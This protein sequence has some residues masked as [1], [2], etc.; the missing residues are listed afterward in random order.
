MKTITITSHLDAE[1][2]LIRR[3]VL[4]PRLLNYVVAGFM[5][6][7][8]IDPGSF[9]DTWHPGSYRV[10]MLALHFLPLGWQHIGI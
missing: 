9:P 3:Y 6:F 10:R 8:P 7:Q 2:D 5:K 4:T 1:P